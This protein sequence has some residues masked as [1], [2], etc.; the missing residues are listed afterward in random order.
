MQA[1]RFGVGFQ[2]EFLAAMDEFLHQHVDSVF[3]LAGPLHDRRDQGGAVLA[4]EAGRGFRGGNTG[5]FAVAEDRAQI[6]VVKIRKIF[7]VEFAAAGVVA[8]ERGAKLACSN[9]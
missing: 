4:H 6:G 2:F 5:G 1:C 3:A 7:G 9:A 8:G